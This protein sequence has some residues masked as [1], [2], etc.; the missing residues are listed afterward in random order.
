MSSEP[1]SQQIRFGNLTYLNESVADGA[2]WITPECSYNSVLIQHEFGGDT[3]RFRRDPNTYF[4]D[5]S[6]QILK[7]LVQ[8]LTVILDEML[9]EAL[10][11]NG[12]I[13]GK[14]PQSKVEKLAGLLKDKH[15]WSAQGCLELIAARNVLTHAGGRWNQESIR[16]VVRFLSNP[17]NPGEK[18]SVGFPVLFRYRKALRTFLNEVTPNPRKASART[19]LAS[20]RP[21]TSRGRISPPEQPSAG[22]S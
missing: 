20:I 2:I 17:P 4:G 6:R 9:S 10:Q 14:Y 3:P 19:P 1:D 15:K 18:L 13:A 5:V 8:D 16:I 12:L 22:N 7:M 21:K 11:E